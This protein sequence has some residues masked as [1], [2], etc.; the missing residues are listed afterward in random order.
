MRN[1]ISSVCYVCWPSLNVL[2][3]FSL[4]A[5]RVTS[6]S[7]LLHQKTNSGC[8]TLSLLRK[9]LLT[10]KCTSCDAGRPES[11][12]AKPLEKKVSHLVSYSSEVNGMPWLCYKFSFFLRLFQWMLVIWNPSKKDFL[13]YNQFGTKKWV[14]IGYAIPPLLLLLKSSFCIRI[15]SHTRCFCYCTA[16]NSECEKIRHNTA[17]SSRQSLQRIF[18]LPASLFNPIHKASSWLGMRAL[19]LEF[20]LKG[21]LSQLAN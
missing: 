17:I 12:G 10:K 18:L 21:S 3:M 19:I 14:H 2:G 5:W 13:H 4:Y 8:H 11:H 7:A 20:S 9:N 15:W 16:R 6:Y 1:G